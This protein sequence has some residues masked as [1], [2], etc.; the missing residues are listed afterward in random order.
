MATINIQEILAQ[1]MNGLMTVSMMSI[2]STQMMTLTASSA[3]MGAGMA[4]GAGASKKGPSKK[5]SETEKTEWVRPTYAGHTYNMS[6]MQGFE[7]TPEDI[8]HLVDNAKVEGLQ[9]KAHRKP[10]MVMIRGKLVNIE[11]YAAQEAREVAP[12]LLPWEEAPEKKPFAIRRPNPPG[13]AGTKSSFIVIKEYAIE[14]RR[15]ASG[16]AIYVYR[17]KKGMR[18]LYAKASGLTGFESQRLVKKTKEVIHHMPDFFAPS[19]FVKLEGTGIS[20]YKGFVLEEMKTGRIKQYKIY[21][22]EKQQAAGNVRW[23]APNYDTALARINN[24]LRDSG[25]EAERELKGVYKK[26]PTAKP[27]VFVENYKGYIITTQE[28]SRRGSPVSIFKVY[29]NLFMYEK[30]DN[31]WTEVNIQSAKRKIDKQTG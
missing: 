31:I 29:Q 1:G 14:L 11:E 3:G 12:E 19:K 10:S 4:A 25:V 28:M 9:L 5:G 8:Q 17:E 24:H 27:E 16:Y 15:S 26:A 22:N 21:D 13:S 20:T 23:Y 30:K 2:M 18:K 6:F 7:R